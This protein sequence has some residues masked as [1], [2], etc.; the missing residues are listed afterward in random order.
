MN[1][2][3]NKLTLSVL[4]ALAA[5]IALVYTL[6]MYHSIIFAVAGMSVLF[7]ITAYIL[8]QNIITYISMRNKSADVQLKNMID[9][10]TTPV[11]GIAVSQA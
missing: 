10:L 7:L 11:E 4:A 5:G 1:K 9:D 8:T 3:D 6:I 2:Q